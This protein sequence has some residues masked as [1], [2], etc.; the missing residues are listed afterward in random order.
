MIKNK[1]RLYEINGVMPHESERS[2]D[3]TL[4]HMLLDVVKC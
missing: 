2:L 1:N 4:Y 3:M